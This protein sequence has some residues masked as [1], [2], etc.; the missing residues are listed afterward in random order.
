MY[1]DP[2][3]WDALMERLPT[4]PRSTS[5]PRPTP[6]P[7]RSRSSIAGSATLGPDDYRRFVQPH[8][9]RLFARLDPDVPVI[10]FGTDT[11]SL[12][13]LQRDAGGDVIGLDW[14]VELGAAPGHG[15][16]PASAVQGNLDPVV[17]LAPPAEIDAPG[18]PHPRRGRR[19]ARPHL[20]PRPRHPAAHPRRP[21]P[22]PGRLR[23]RGIGPV[24]RPSRTRT[25]NRL[26]PAQSAAQTAKMR[27]LIESR[28]AC[29]A[30]NRATRQALIRKKPAGPI[31]H[32]PRA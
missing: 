22:G 3:A 29:H 7:R 18:P 4:R 32:E 1:R 19:P 14:R 6:A 9:H 30:F 26:D 8:M 21:R 15:S 12:L 28:I 25:L 17:L 20:Q 13:E 16:A 2:G 5:T 24:A 23:P 10:H 11:G 31:F 27:G